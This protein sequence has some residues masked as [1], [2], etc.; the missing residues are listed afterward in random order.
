MCYNVQNNIYKK[1]YFMP[2]IVS[3]LS[4]QYK[5]FT[6][7]KNDLKKLLASGGHGNPEDMA[8][9]KSLE[10]H[11]QIQADVRSERPVYYLDFEKA[12]EKPCILFFHGGSFLTGLSGK[13]WRFIRRLLFGTGCPAVVPDYPLIPEHTHRY[14]LS[15][16]AELYQDLITK[17]PHGVIL[18]GDDAGA[19]LAMVVA[20]QTIRQNIPSPSQ[21]L[22]LSPYLDFSGNNPIK[23]VLAHRDPVLELSACKEAALLY[24]GSRSLNDPLVSPVFGSMQGLP[25]ITVWTG[26]NDILY[27][28]SLLLKEALQ[29]A[30]TPYHI[31]TYPGM[32][33]GWMLERIPEGRKALRQIVLTIREYL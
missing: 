15:F 18:V 22:L 19:S 26:D 6:N 14:I 16:C 21:L 29:R 12:E 2:S 32:V 11:H 7:A 13:H 1:E 5:V 30:H 8:P 10:K 33:H 23:N 4:Y 9:P 3:S 24:A 25:K 28:D 17:C 31:Y 27:A 20:Q